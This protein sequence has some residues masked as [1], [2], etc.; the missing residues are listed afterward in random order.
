MTDTGTVDLI[1]HVERRVG[2]HGIKRIT[3][4]GIEKA[5][6]GRMK[7][8]GKD[9]VYRFDGLQLFDEPF[10]TREARQRIGMR[11]I[12]VHRPAL[13]NH[14]GVIGACDPG[15]KR[16]SLLSNRELFSERRQK[17]DRRPS[18]R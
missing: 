17:A 1:E 13:W 5:L 12:G 15:V 10:D 2:L 8:L 3:G 9:R 16:A 11:R 6:R 7:L 18:F 4:K 14:A